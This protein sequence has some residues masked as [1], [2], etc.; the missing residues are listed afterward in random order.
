MNIEHL[1]QLNIELEGLLRVLANRE[2]E[3]ARRL[4]NIKYNEFKAAF[5]QS[6]PQPVAESTPKPVPAPVVESAPIV[7]P[8]PV[9]VPEP[10]VE[11]VVEVEPIVVAAPEVKIQP[12]EPQV[13][14]DLEFTTADEIAANRQNEMRVD[15]MLTRREARDLRK[16][17]TL[18]DKFRFRRELFS[19]NDAQFADTLNVLS[20]MQNFDEAVEYMRDDLGWDMDNDDVKDFVNIISNHFATV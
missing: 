11:P 1:I 6:E 12:I 5:E 8:E 16:A 20:A 13:H 3:D 4:L 9:V 17:F 19:N 14:A 2:N 7:E 10:T 15:E 18:N